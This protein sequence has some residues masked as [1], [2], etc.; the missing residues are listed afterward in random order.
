LCSVAAI[1][2]IEK[3]LSVEKSCCLYDMYLS[4]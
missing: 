2:D 1:L 4:V 3:M